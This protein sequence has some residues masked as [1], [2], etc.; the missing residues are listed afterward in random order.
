MFKNRF[1]LIVAV[2]SLLLVTM[3]VS[4][5]F[6]NASTSADLSWPQRPVIIPVTGANSL[7]DYHERHPDLSA[8]AESTANSNDDFFQRYPG[9]WVSRAAGVAV[10][11]T[12]SSAAPDYFQRHP[13]L[14][15]SANVPVD[16]CVDVSMGELAACRRSVQTPILTPGLACESPVDC[17]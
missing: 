17:R 14:N 8:S 16:E 9:Q 10:P 11:V 12:G 13:A 2:L 5:P 4:R 3:A 1:L 15:A 7:S 6:S